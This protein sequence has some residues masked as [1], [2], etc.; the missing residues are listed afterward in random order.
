MVLFFSCLIIVAV[1][2]LGFTIYRS[3]MNLVE[4]SLGAQAQLIAEKAASLIDPAEYATL[5][6]TDGETEYYTSLRTILNELRETNGLKYLYTL[7][8]GEENGEAYYYYMVDGAPP[9]VAED[10]FSPIGTREDNEYPDMI[11]AFAEGRA[12]VGE[13]TNDEEYGA[14]ITA[15]VPLKDTNG[16]LIGLLGA[17]YDASKVYW[18]L[19][20]NTKTALYVAAGVIAAG[21]ALIFALASY[22]TRPLNQLTAHIAKVREGDMTV[23]IPIHRKDE[24]GHLAHTFRELVANTRSV[25]RSIRDNSERLLA[26]SQD[27]SQHARSTT[28]ASQQIAASIQEA[29]NGAH[30]QVNRAASITKAVEGMTS[31][32]LRITESASV[33]SDVAKE[34]KTHSDRGKLL[35]GQAMLEMEAIGYAAETMLV[36]TKQ[37]EQRSNEIGDITIVM[38]DIASQTNLLA[39]NA[40]IEAA[41]AGENGK[42]FAVVAEHVRKLAV[43]SQSF[44]IKI[45]ELISNMQVQTTRLAEGMAGNTDKVHAG[46]IVVK[47]AGEAFY[48]IV[49]G[50]AH[51]HSQLQQVSSASQEVSVEAKEVEASVG[52]MEQI[53]RSA[54]QHFQGIATH[55]SAQMAAMDEVT[56]SAESLKLMSNELTSLNKKFIV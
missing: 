3:S 7:G 10:D 52:E 31:S 45:A 43:Q 25:I 37:L 27:V 4:N 13:L 12:V 49:E 34:T 47:E 29:T 54:A 42:G 5:K 19:V 23:D 16:A 38:A 46:L 14:I 26:A 20:H 18:L 17:D 55:S 15:Y 36:A 6:A 9:D 24:I 44:A 51:V 8:K 35:I 2:V 41:R 11:R 50:L 30:L 39:L 33:V 40:A 21:I 32:M 53:S 28:A 22:L 1:A 48:S 56:G